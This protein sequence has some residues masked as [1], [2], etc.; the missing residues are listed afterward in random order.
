MVIYQI[1][2]LINGKKYIGRD[3]LNRPGYLGGGTA[4]K[5]AIKKYGRKNFSKIVIEV[6]K[7]YK[8]LLEREEYWLNFY[9]VV[10]DSNFYNMITS[11]NGW[12]K[13]KSRPERLGKI[14]SQETRDRISKA[15]KGKTGKTS[16]KPIPVIQYNFK[17]IK[18]VINEYSSSIIAENITG[19][20]S[21]DIKMV[22]RGKQ[23][24][25]GGFIWGY[26]NLTYNIAK[27]SRESIPVIQYKYEIIKTKIAEFPSA[28]EASRVTGILS[29][30]IRAVIKGKQNT[31]GGFIW[32]K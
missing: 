3:S 13:G 6:C 15:G 9:N 7:D 5:N 17:I 11:S 24:T 29:C 4:I 21:H 1:E 10:K 8:H 28:A 32:G 30:D 26:K 18:S 27:K 14:N 12:E 22:A 20:S 19:V 16:G 23:N 25:A 2:N 31:A